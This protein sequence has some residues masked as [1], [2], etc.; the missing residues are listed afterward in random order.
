MFQIEFSTKKVSCKVSLPLLV[1]NL[2]VFKVCY[3]EINE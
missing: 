2:H 1:E 3:E